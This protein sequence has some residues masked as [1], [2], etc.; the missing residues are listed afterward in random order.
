MQKV[1]RPRVAPPPP[2]RRAVAVAAFALALAVGCTGPDAGPQ[3]APSLQIVDQLHDNGVTGFFGLPPVVPRPAP[4][5]DVIPTATP[6]DRPSALSPSPLREHI[7]ATERGA[8]VAALEAAA[9]NQSQAARDLG[10]TRRALIYRME[11]HGLKPV[12]R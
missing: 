12:A 4:Y 5:G 6:A 7:D 11:R 10:I 8:L 1:H 2:E 9:W 3:P